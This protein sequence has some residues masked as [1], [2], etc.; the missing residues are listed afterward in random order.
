MIDERELQKALNE[1]DTH[2]RTV[3]AHM[4]EFE[5]KLNELTIAAAAPMPTLP[6]K[7]GFYLTQ[8]YTVLRRHHDGE[9]EM[10]DNSGSLRRVY[11][12]EQGLCSKLGPDASRW[13][14]SVK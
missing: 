10:F 6:D 2:V 4:R 11:W 8:R 13:C 5:D 7:P 1:L 9:W 3:K 12:G 14:H